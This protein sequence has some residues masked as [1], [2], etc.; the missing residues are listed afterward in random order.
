VVIKGGPGDP[1]VEPVLPSGGFCI[2]APLLANGP[3]TLFVYALKDGIISPP[4]MVTV[5]QDASAAIPQSPMCQ[6]MEQATCTP[7]APSSSDCSDGK[8]NDCN[9]LVDE[10]DPGCNMCQDDA[11][12]PN[13]TPF[14]VPE[15]AVGGYSLQICPCAPDWF[16]F[17][18]NAGDI[19]HTKITFDTTVVDLDMMLQTP[20]QAESND[21]ANLAISEGTTNTE[22]ITYTA[23][24]AGTYYIK[25]YPYSANGFGP[26]HLTIY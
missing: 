23:T 18:V 3:T 24:T 11:L 9:G 8:D 15:I 4:A 26:Y 22:E 10:C 1:V 19:I 7:E 12:G 20:K 14:F 16:S 21:T 13:S 6:G 5:T 17:T 2:D 25:V